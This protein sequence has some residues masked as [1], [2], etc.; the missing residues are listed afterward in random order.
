[1][2]VFDRSYRRYTGEFKWAGLAGFLTDCML[3]GDG[4]RA[5]SWIGSRMQ[6]NPG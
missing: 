2:S 6:W 3:P 4:E 5:E 1:M